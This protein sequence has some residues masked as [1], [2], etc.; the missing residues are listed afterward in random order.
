MFPVHEWVYNILIEAHYGEWCLL[1]NNPVSSVDRQKLHKTAG[2]NNLSPI[3]LI[4]H[5]SLHK[6]PQDPVLSSIA[7][8]GPSWAFG[9][10]ISSLS[11]SVQNLVIPQL[12]T[13]GK[14]L[15]SLA[16]R[17]PQWTTAFSVSLITWVQFLEPTADLY[18]HMTHV[19]MYHAHSVMHWRLSLLHVHILFSTIRGSQHVEMT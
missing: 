11:H 18:R 9:R 15:D 12:S 8:W 1:K 6:H 7:C 4:S 5:P 13:H 17:M 19:S 10:D 16:N 14:E 2:Q 3:S